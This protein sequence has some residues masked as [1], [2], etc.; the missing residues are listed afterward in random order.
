MN[1]IFFL[2]FFKSEIFSSKISIIQ[3]CKPGSVV[4]YLFY[5]IGIKQAF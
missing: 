2:M 5:G 3:F 1:R 4:K